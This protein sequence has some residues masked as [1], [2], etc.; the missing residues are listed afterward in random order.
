M[1]AVVLPDPAGPTINSNGAI[2]CHRTTRLRLTRTQT[3]RVEVPGC[4]VD[5]VG[6]AA[7]ALRPLHD[8]FFL[9]EDRLGGEGRLMGA[10]LIGRPSRRSTAPSGTGGDRSTH[11]SAPAWSASCCRNP[12]S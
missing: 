7:L 4:G 11:R 10:S 2:P 5:D 6:E 12:T 9:V 8:L 3:P 1:R